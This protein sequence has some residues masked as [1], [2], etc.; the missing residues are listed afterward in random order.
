MTITQ[1]EWEVMTFPD[2]KAILKGEKYKALRKTVENC[3][4]VSIDNLSQA[5]ISSSVSFFCLTFLVGGRGFI[6]E[7]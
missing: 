1:E 7:S 3:F 4:G 6:G 2:H 5:V